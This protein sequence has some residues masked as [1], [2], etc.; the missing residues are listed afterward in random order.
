MRPVSKRSPVSSTLE[1]MNFL[2]M[3]GEGT[4]T[5]ALQSSSL[6][7]SVLLTMIFLRTCFSLD[8]A[9]KVPA[10]NFPFKSGPDFLIQVFGFKPL[11]HR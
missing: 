5:E 9:A 7:L 6:E 4:H 11:V 10:W 1:L 2:R 8:L 3:L